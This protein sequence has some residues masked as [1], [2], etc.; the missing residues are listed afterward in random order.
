M[1]KLIL[2]L[3]IAA[4]ASCSKSA[5][6]TPNPTPNPPNP[7]PTDPISG[8]ANVRFQLS[9]PAAVMA[10]PYRY[11]NPADQLFGQN[12]A[13]KTDTFCLFPSSWV[14]SGMDTTELVASYYPTFKPGTYLDSSFQKIEG[15]SLANNNG[16]KSARWIYQTETYPGLSLPY[17]TVPVAFKVSGVSLSSIK[18]V[19]VRAI[20]PDYWRLLVT[21]GSAVNAWFDKTTAASD[22]TLVQGWARLDKTKNTVYQ[23]GS[24]YYFVTPAPMIVQFRAPVNWQMQFLLTVNYT[25]GSKTEQMLLYHK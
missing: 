22:Y 9:L 10:A 15:I 2:V 3:A 18:S 21:L 1:K 6:P 5:D 16:H 20:T 11:Y 7:T 23:V 13:P 17:D 8:K 25:D 19:K 12:P 24:D 14:V 4:M